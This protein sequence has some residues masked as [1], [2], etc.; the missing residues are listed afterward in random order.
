LDA[1]KMAMMVK[2]KRILDER[3]EEELIVK[4]NLEKA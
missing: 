3:D 1:N 2:E 4:Y